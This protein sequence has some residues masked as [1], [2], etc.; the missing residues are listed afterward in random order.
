MLDVVEDVVEDV[1]V[2]DGN[3]IEDGDVVEDVP[4]DALIAA[5]PFE[6]NGI[7]QS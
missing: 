6:D 3:G 5:L 4:M 1:S 2:E 7:V